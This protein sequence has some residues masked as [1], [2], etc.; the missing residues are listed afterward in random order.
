M[1]GRIHRLRVHHS[2]RASLTIKIQMKRLTGRVKGVFCSTKLYRYMSGP[3]RLISFVL[4]RETYVVYINH[5]RMNRDTSL[6]CPWDLGIVTC[7]GDDDANKIGT[8]SP[9]DRPKPDVF[10]FSRRDRKPR[11]RFPVAY[12]PLCYPLYNVTDSSSVT[13]RLC[14][15]AFDAPNQA[16]YLFPSSRSP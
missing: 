7:S 4:L 14:N 8:D 1:N 15:T 13:E 10:E 6:P 3:I 12:S 9:H 11:H 5:Y 16:K 2:T